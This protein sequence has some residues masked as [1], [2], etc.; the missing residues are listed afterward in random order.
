[1]SKLKNFLFFLLIIVELILI[2]IFFYQQLD[3]YYS[4]FHEYLKIHFKSFIIMN[5]AFLMIIYTLNSHNFKKN[6]EYQSLFISLLKE[7]IFLG[8]FLFAI[9]GV[10]ENRLVSNRGLFIIL[11]EIFF[12]FLFL[13]FFYLYIIKLSYKKGF[14]LKKI[15]IL[16]NNDVK[17]SFIKTISKD[18]SYGLEIVGHEEIKNIEDICAQRLFSIIERYKDVRQM[19][20]FMNEDYSDKFIQKLSDFCENNLLTLNIVPKIDS[21]LNSDLETVYIDRFR[22]LIYKELPF[23]NSIINYTKRLFDILFSLIITI[24]IL[25]WLVPLLAIIIKLTSKGP[26]FFLQERV[27]FEGSP[28]KI[29]KFRTMKIDAEKYGPQLAK[30]KDPRITKIGRFLRKYRIDEL[31]QFINVLKGDMSIVGPRPERRYYINKILEIN[32]RYKKLHNL[33]P[34]ITSLGQVYYGYAETIKEMSERL[35]YDLLYLNNYNFLMDLKIILLTI[36]V[37][38]SGKGK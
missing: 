30:N 11:I 28:F 10:R 17:K 3:H 9:A 5:L 2:N 35:K 38:I 29:I 8:L 14:N 25:S 37:M 7:M 20:F 12:S 24:C 31:P 33:K 18:R 26:I 22:I 4:S 1:M 6:N 19:Y 21:F 23:E 15:I 34:G 27:G 13:R 32:P 36:R 16:G